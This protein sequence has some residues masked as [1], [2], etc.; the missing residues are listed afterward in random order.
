MESPFQG[1]Y[2]SQALCESAS[3]TE[4][5]KLEFAGFT[6]PKASRY[7]RPFHLHFAFARRLDRHRGPQAIRLEE[8]IQDWL[9]MG[10]SISVGEEKTPVNEDT[11][12]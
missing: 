4:P 6:C 1:V 8:G 2:Q 5:G 3:A 9:A 12:R 10:F 7:C 11:K